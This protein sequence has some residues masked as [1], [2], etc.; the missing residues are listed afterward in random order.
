M[1]TGFDDGAAVYADVAPAPA[2]ESAHVLV[3]LHVSLHQYGINSD[4]V[5][6]TASDDR[7]GNAAG[8]DLAVEAAVAQPQV[9]DGRSGV[10]ANESANVAGGLLNVRDGVPLSVYGGLE[11]VGG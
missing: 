5:L 7:A 10:V 1:E 11:G 6:L 3:G 9:G 8:N 4:G 2:Y